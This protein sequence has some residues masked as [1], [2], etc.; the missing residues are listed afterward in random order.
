MSKAIIIEVKDGV[1]DVRMGT[2]ARNG[3]LLGTANEQVFKRQDSDGAVTGFEIHGIA[4]LDG[5]AVKLSPGSTEGFLSVTEAAK[6]LG[7]TRN[8]ILHLIWAG[9]VKGVTK[10]AGRWMIP[11]PV[12][13]TPRKRGRVGV[14]G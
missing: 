1:L 3:R 11:T 5:L 8:R 7:V 9:R 6:E 4:G 2:K 10:V 12:E 13:M 14:A